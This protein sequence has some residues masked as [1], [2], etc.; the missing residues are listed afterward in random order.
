MVLIY[1]R[2]SILESKKYITNIRGAGIAR[3]YVCY[4]L[5]KHVQTRAIIKARKEDR[6]KASELIKLLKKNGCYLVEHGKEHDKWHSDITGKNFMVPRHG[7]KEIATGTANRIFKD[8]GL[9]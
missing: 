4:R 6:M 9:R 5:L 1:Q 2:F 8:A 7:G 3:I